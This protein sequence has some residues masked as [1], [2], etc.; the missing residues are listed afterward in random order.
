[1]PMVD[2]GKC[3]AAVLEKDFWSERMRS[4]LEDSR[5]CCWV[6]EAV[7]MVVSLRKGS[8]R[9]ASGAAYLRGMLDLERRLARRVEVAVVAQRVVL[10]HNDLFPI[11]ILSKPT[12]IRN[13]YRLAA[14]R[15]LHSRILLLVVL[16]ESRFQRLQQARIVS[17]QSLDICN[18]AL[19]AESLA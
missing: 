8:F 15:Q 2:W 13:P 17:S 1:M 5:G 16:P 18:I 6:L 9:D 11:S 4:A 7:W 3:S 19:A 14:S 12:K 10:A